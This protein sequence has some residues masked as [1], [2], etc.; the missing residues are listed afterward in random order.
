MPELLAAWPFVL[1]GGAAGLLIGCVG[2]GGVII[3]PALVYLLD[4]PIHS[5]LAAAMF[6]FVPSGIV[7]TAVFARNGSIRWDM[8]ARLWAGAMPAAFAGALVATAVAPAV[9]EAAVGVLAAA[10]GAHALLGGGASATRPR[11]APSARMLLG[12][13]AFTGLTSSLTGTGGPLVLVPILVWLELPVLLAIGL[14]QTIQLPI[15]ALATAGYVVGGTLDVAIGVSIGAGI[16]AGTWVGARVAHALPRTVL[17]RIVAALLVVVGASILTGLASGSARASA[18]R[19]A[20]ARDAAA[21]A[22]AVLERDRAAVV[23]D[24]LAA[25]HEADAGAARLRREKRD[26]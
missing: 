6:A 3:V 2:I 21:R 4:V 26:P 1:L 19:Q 25:Q 9:I 23:L 20:H 18:E 11:A 5:A 12:A 10:S 13:G 17:R 22:G 16:V 15:A 7:G 8:T 14:A 24:D